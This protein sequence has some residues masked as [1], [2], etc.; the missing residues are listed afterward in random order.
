MKNNSTQNGLNQVGTVPI[1]QANSQIV[2]IQTQDHH[3]EV[4]W[5][6]RYVQDI[7]YAQMELPQF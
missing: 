1:Y 6:R 5:K 2:Q 7:V 3:S 4:Y